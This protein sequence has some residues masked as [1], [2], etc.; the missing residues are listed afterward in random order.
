MAPSQVSLDSSLRNARIVAALL[1]LSAL[2]Y[3]LIGETVSTESPRDVKSFLLVFG[4]LTLW[5]VSSAFAIRTRYLESATRTLRSN[6][7]DHVALHRWKFG[8][9]AP[10][11]MCEAIALFGL[12]VR[13]LG[14]TSLQTI[15]FYLIS[16]SMMVVWW[17]RR[18]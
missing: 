10:L 3:I 5:D 9:I 16:A 13:F 12:V 2:L 6:P 7:E 1:F 15:P 11:A 18:P 14:G 4:L 8:Q 17:P